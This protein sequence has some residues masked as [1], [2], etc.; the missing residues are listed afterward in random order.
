M[1]NNF[2]ICTYSNFGKSK[3]RIIFA[4]K[5]NIND[6]LSR[7]LN[8]DLFLDTFTYNAHTTGSD[9]LWCGI[10]IVT[11]LGSSFASRV[12]AS[13]LNGVNLTKLI[14]KTS[15]EYFQLAYFFSQNRSELKKIKDHLINNRKK[16]PLFNS[17]LFCKNLENSYKF[18]INNYNHK[19][20]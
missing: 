1:R 11:K 5:T 17:R 7:H 20:F 6:H 19:I 14:T 9:A 18:M 2:F 8:A 13:L 10:P 4:P 3:N 15:E 16:H 12:C